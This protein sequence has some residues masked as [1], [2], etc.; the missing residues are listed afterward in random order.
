MLQEPANSVGL[1]LCAGENSCLH[2]VRAPE[3]PPR[4]IYQIVGNSP[5]A[6]ATVANLSPALA[7][8]LGLDTLARGVIVLGV[9]SRSPAR[10]M[11]L[12]RGDFIIKVNGRE[13]ETVAGLKRLVA[14]RQPEWHLSIRRGDQT[15]NLVVRG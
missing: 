1:F 8:E 12:K 4:D 10:R 13:V 7:E 3:E 2:L 6:G 15:F 14:A 5:L 9:A 11:K